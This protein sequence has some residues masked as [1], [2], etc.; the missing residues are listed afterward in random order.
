MEKV[1]FDS[2]YTFKYSPRKGTKAVGYDDQVN[3]KG[4]KDIGKID[5]LLN[6]AIL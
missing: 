1:K 5:K 3:E 6:L 2:A 4:K